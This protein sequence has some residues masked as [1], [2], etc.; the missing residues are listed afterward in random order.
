MEPEDLR[1][2]LALVA[3]Y[4]RTIDTEQW[5]AHAALWSE[6]CHLL[7]FESDYVGREAILEFLKSA[8]KGKHITAVPHIEFDGGCAQAGSD[9]VF[10]DPDCTLFSAG[11]Y[12]DEFVREGGRWRIHRRKISIDFRGNG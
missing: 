2:I 12:D 1:Q 11:H 10:F 9:Y 6:E 3:D 8:R 4:G 7:V 5:E